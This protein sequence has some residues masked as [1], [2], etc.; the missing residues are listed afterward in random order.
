[1]T[2]ERVPPGRVLTLGGLSSFGPLALDL[3]LPALPQLTASLGTSESL[4]QA[5]MSV[6]MIGLAVGQLLFGPVTDR[7][8]R[9]V[10]LLVGVAAFAVTAGLCAVA[11][12]IEVLLAL[13]LLT[14]L[15]GAVG[16]VT[17]RAIVRD[18]YDGPAVARM[19][20]LLMLVNGAAPILAPVLGSQLMRLTD[21]RGLFVALAVIGAVLFLA[22]LT[23]AETLPPSARGTGGLAGVR[24]AMRRVLADRSFVVPV[25]VLSLTASGMFVYI[26]LGSYVLQDGYGL[27]AQAYGLMFA[28]NALGI[29]A[30]GQLS[31]GLAPRVGP[32]PVLRAGVA[33]ALTGAVALLVGVLVAESVWAV[34]VPLFLVVSSVGLLLPNGTALALDGQ[35]EVAGTASGVLGLAQFSFGA[36][37]G[38][39]VSLGGVTGV[40]MA[41]T[42]LAVVAAGAVVSLLL[43]PPRPA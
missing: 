29:V 11:P 8:G 41:V 34:L 19:F 31:G 42:I 37:I 10:P 40:S 17:A 4:G 32:L 25:L 24:R 13:R 21:W 35:K 38:P 27:S 22:A 12:S 18:L 36:V 20:S 6:C 33:V 16:I 7:Y 3:Y 5:S 2:A 28:A 43:R 9:R 30:A 15:A 39:L 26:A 1:V 14:G 23:Q